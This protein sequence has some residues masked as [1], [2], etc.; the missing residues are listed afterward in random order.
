MRN[1]LLSMI[2]ALG[3]Y[4]GVYAS[5]E[6]VNDMVISESIEITEY[7]NLETMQYD[8]VEFAAPCTAS[9]TVLNP[10]TGQSQLR[11]FNGT[12]DGVSDCHSQINAWLLLYTNVGFTIEDQSRSYNGETIP[13]P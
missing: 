12:S 11:Y 4:A 13:N 10:N 5:N 3:S 7:T 6:V 2:V 8:I 1:F 9:A